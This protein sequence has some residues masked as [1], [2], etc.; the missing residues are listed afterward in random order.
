VLTAPG[1]LP[2]GELIGA[3]LTRA[4]I[5]QRTRPGRCLLNV[6]DGNLVTVTVPLG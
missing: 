1:S 4:M 5:G 2:D 3:R 6:G